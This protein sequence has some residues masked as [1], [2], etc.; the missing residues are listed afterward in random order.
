MG[1]GDL[2]GVRDGEDDDG[3]GGGGERRR[4]GKRRCGWPV[5]G[6]RHT[7][8]WYKRGL[9]PVS[10]FW[11]SPTESFSARSRFTLRTR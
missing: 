4:A 6:Q 8:S 9:M 2:K 3:G 1:G 7:P 10:V 5:L 11:L